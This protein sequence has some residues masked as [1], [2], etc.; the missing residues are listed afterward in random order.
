MI[1]SMAV[2]V[3]ADQLSAEQKGLL[4]DLSAVGAAT[5]L[6]FE[7]KTGRLGGHVREEFVE[8]EKAGL[9]KRTIYTGGT[10]NEVFSLLPAGYAVARSERSRDHKSDRQ[11]I[12]FT[13]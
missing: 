4:I 2:V 8:L 13:E 12:L 5:P 3:T 9:I 11:P 7:L 6:Q 1:E 10:E